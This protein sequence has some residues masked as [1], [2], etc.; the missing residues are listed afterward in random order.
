MVLAFS[1][2]PAVTF[3]MSRPS[4]REVASGFYPPERAGELTFAWTSRRAD[5]K[6]AG[7][8]RATEWR[9]AVRLRGGRGPELPL[10]RVDVA[11]D[12]LSVAE[13]TVTNTF[14][15]VPFTRSSPARPGA[16]S[17]HH[18]RPDVRA[19]PIGHTRA[20]RHG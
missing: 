15:D 20:R 1:L 18:E 3:D 2:H 13:R 16:E 5:V 17:V 4:P 8:N 11:A 14:E 19:G 7:L 10:P 9:C 6:L 12:G